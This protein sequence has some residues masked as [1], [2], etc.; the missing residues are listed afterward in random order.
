M[1]TFSI[2]QYMGL[3]KDRIYSAAIFETRRKAGGGGGK[4]EKTYKLLTDLLV[5][6]GN[7]F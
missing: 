3:Q 2:L 5:I 4:S 6:E 7:D 1:P